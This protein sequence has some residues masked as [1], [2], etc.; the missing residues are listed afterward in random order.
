[1]EAGPAWVLAAAHEGRTGRYEAVGGCTQVDTDPEAANPVLVAEGILLVV[2][3]ILVAGAP[4]AEDSLAV[5]VGILVAVDIPE[6]HDFQEKTDCSAPKVRT[7]MVARCSEVQKRPQACS[8]LVPTKLYDNEGKSVRSI[9]IKSDQRKHPANPT[10]LRTGTGGC[11][12]LTSLL[13]SGHN[14]SPSTFDCF[15]GS[16]AESQ[17][18]LPCGPKSFTHSTCRIGPLYSQLARTLRLL[19]VSLLRGAAV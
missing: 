18:S 4:A 14:C 8:L 6:I 16:V 5:A 7:P 9:R 2:V 19:T 13:R 12:R 10:N 3:G 1:V 11:E 17:N 15:L